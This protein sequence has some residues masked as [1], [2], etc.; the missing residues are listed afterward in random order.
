MTATISFK[1]RV[2]K[3][4]I[5]VCLQAIKNG[6]RSF[7]D[8]LCVLEAQLEAMMTTQTEPKTEP[9]YIELNSN[10]S[11]G[12]NAYLVQEGSGY[13]HND[14][15]TPIDDENQQR[16]YRKKSHVVKVRIDNLADG[17]YRFVE[18][19]GQY[20]H[21]IE[22]GWLKIING[23]IVQQ[24]DTLPSLVVGTD[25]ESLPELEGSDKQIDWAFSIREKAIAK[26]KL[27]QKPI[28]D[29]FFTEKSAK[30]WIDKHDKI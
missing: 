16:A 6:L 24:S 21:K 8:R 5:Q 23:Q 1:I 29:W 11:K 3:H 22:K 12:I 15:G 14:Y 2:I 4:Q 28:P 30:I 26:L 19:A 10:R 20:A 17:I 13:Q 18:A 7:V 27:Q 25:A 9:K